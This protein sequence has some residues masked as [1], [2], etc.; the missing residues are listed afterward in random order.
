MTKQ[1][2]KEVVEIVKT[3]LPHIEGERDKANFI[4]FKIQIEAIEVL[5]DLAQEYLKVDG[6]EEKKIDSE[7]APTEL[8]S[9][10][11]FAYYQAYLMRK[12]MLF[13]DEQMGRK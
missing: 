12:A 3:I 4:K 11:A 2:I 6:I 5:L 1:K 10:E 8:N 9:D 7:N 13:F